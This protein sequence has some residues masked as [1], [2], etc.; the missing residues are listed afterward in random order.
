MNSSSDEDEDSGRNERKEPGALAPRLQLAGFVGPDSYMSEGSEDYHFIP[1]TGE[2][3]DY[4]EY[5]ERIGTRTSLSWFQRRSVADYAI[6]NFLF[7]ENQLLHPISNDYPMIIEHI[8]LSELA[9]NLNRDSDQFNV[10][11]VMNTLFRLAEEQYPREF[12]GRRGYSYYLEWRQHSVPIP[13]AVVGAIPAEYED[14]VDVEADNFATLRA[15]VGD[16]EMMEADQRE[17]K[18]EHD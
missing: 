8:G 1:P 7:W 12:A 5:G 11:I 10:D 13:N 14:Y 6:Y 4:N 17:D 2:V 16:D 9:R 3:R 18:I 15:V